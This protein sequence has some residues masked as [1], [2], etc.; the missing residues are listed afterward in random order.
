MGT[1]WRELVWVASPTKYGGVHIQ[2]VDYWNLLC[3]LPMAVGM[4]SLRYL[5][6]RFVSEIRADLTDQIL[7]RPARGVPRD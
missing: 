3:P 4:L 7:F 6:Q 1:L 5:L 2:Y